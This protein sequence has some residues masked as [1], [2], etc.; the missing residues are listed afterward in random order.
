[1][2]SVPKT[3]L[4]RHLTVWVSFFGH[5]HA[6][7]RQRRW[8]LDPAPFQALVGCL[9]GCF[10]VFLLVLLNFHKTLL[11][12]PVPW[13]VILANVRNF[14]CDTR[15]ILKMWWWIWD[16]Y[17]AFCYGD[18]KLRFKSQ[19]IIPV[20]TPKLCLWFMS[21]AHELMKCW[22]RNMSSFIHDKLCCFGDSGSQN[23][24]FEVCLEIQVLVTRAWLNRL[25]SE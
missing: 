12:F 1:M 17:C 11:Q 19:A 25:N 15:S 20:F 10:M 13:R 8:V 24:V 6:L 23:S 18:P 16:F 22:G 3:P 2:E 4:S 9:R 14:Y 7:T 21:D 5:A